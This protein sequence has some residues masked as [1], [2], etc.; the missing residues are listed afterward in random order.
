MQ[1]KDYDDDGKLSEKDIE[2]H[3]EYLKIVR[4]EE[5][6]NTQ[7][8]VV[9]VSVISMLMFTIAM[10]TPIISESRVAI[11]ADLFG[12]FYIAQASIVGFYF[13][14]QAYMTKK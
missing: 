4:V 5:K 3:D 2:L 12:L 13:G 11:L 1:I 6:A 9:W 10:M 7:R 8:R 14:A